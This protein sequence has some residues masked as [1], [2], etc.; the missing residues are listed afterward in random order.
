MNFYKT[1]NGSDPLLP[2]IPQGVKT[3]RDEDMSSKRKKCSDCKIHV[4]YIDSYFSAVF[5]QQ[6][7]QSHDQSRSSSLLSPPASML[8]IDDVYQRMTSWS[9][10]TEYSRC[11][12]M[13]L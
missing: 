3:I 6:G 7:S 2:E 9:E 1:D 12:P 5:S 4:V 8:D 13:P 11:L 10:K